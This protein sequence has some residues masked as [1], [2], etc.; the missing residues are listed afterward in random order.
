MN[1]KTNGR[2]RE[3]FNQDTK[4]TEKWVFQLVLLRLPQCLARAQEGCTYQLHMLASPILVSAAVPTET[5]PCF[6]AMLKHDLGSQAARSSLPDTYWHLCSSSSVPGSSVFLGSLSDHPVYF[7]N[8]Y[9][10]QSQGPV[11]KSLK[12]TS[13]V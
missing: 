5:Q 13:T 2:K 4:D 12:R 9:L 7:N 11:I 6:S 10:G 8:L 1:R 3:R